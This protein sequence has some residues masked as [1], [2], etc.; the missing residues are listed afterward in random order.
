[1]E[2]TLLDLL[3]DLERK[4]V[5]ELRGEWL[6][7][8]GVVSR[9]GE[10]ADPKAV[11]ALERSLARAK[12]FKAL[13]QAAQGGMSPTE[14]GSASPLIAAALAEQ[15]IREIEQALAKCRE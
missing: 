13:C 15:T 8:S 7:D 1:M 9:I 10:L 2:N 11:P 4:R 5:M 3:A 14:P 6:P 12:R